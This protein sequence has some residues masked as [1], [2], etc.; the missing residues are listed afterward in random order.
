LDTSV[1][2]HVTSAVYNFNGSELLASYNDEDI[3]LFSSQRSDVADVLHRYQ[4]HRNNAT[5][6]GVNFYGPRSEFVVSGSDCGNIFFWDKETE[7]IVHCVAGDENGVVNISFLFRG[8]C[9]IS[10][11]KIVYF[12]RATF[13]RLLLVCR[14]LFVLSCLF[15]Y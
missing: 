4:G 7:A 8:K 15:P 6:K 12:L 3:Y 5:V 2:A 9:H 13:P 11:L 14:R 10:S 1:R